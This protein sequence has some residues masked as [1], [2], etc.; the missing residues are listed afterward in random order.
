MG[1]KEETGTLNS[2]ESS[3]G[4]ESNPSL[5][6]GLFQADRPEQQNRNMMGLKTH[7]SETEHKA[8]IRGKDTTGSIESREGPTMRSEGLKGI[9][10][11][12]CIKLNTMG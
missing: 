8:N 12:N 7:P 11:H 10:A 2:S 1:I 4:I 5:I 9:L 6:M 3:Q